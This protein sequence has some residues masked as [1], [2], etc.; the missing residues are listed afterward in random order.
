MKYSLDDIMN[1]FVNGVIGVLSAFGLLCLVLCTIWCLH[2]CKN[3]SPVNGNN[4][5]V[6]NI[7]SV[8][9]VND[10]IKLKVESLDSIKNA[11]IIEVIS[12]NNDSTIK[13]FYELVSE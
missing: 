13:L 5:S 12:L 10:S 11:K 1:P 3:T 4:G 2:Q 8:T 6:V 7:D 9:K